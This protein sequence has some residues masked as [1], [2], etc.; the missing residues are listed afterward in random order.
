M[1]FRTIKIHHH[2]YQRDLRRV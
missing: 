2:R 1:F